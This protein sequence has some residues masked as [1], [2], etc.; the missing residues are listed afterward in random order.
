MKA[1]L[2]GE[3]IKIKIVKNFLISIEAKAFFGEARHFSSSVTQGKRGG[4]K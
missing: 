4:E 2:L 1:S 3:V